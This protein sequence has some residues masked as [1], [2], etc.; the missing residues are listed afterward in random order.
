MSLSDRTGLVIHSP[1]AVAFNQI[2]LRR[3]GWVF[4][5]PPLLFGTYVVMATLQYDRADDRGTLRGDLSV[6]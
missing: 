1:R 3:Q 4:F 6:K 5:S 2:T